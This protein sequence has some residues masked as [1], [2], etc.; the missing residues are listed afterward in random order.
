MMVSFGPPGVETP[1]FGGLTYFEVTNLLR[2]I[3]DEINFNGVS[4]ELA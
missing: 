1:A 2:G 3:A 4:Q